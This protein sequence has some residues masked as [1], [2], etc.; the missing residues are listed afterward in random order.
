L[1]FVFNSAGTCGYTFTPQVLN[2][3]VAFTST[4]LYLTNNIEPQEEYLSQQM[5]AYW[6]NFAYTGNPNT[7]PLSV[8][9]QWPT[10]NGQQLA[11]LLLDTTITVEYAHNA[12]ICDFW[13]SVGYQNP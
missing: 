8:D 12:T 7:G 4:N 13:D 1:P 9:V 6:I 10:F 5:G 11:E 2:S 3:I